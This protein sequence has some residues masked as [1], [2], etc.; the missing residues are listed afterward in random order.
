MEAGWSS[1]RE[2]GAGPWMW[3]L[4]H[5]GLSFLICTMGPGGAPHA[6][7]RPFSGVLVTPLL[8]SQPSPE[9]CADPAG[10]WGSGQLCLPPAVLGGNSHSWQCRA[11]PRLGL[12]PLLTPLPSPYPVG[13]PG[14]DPP[15]F[16]P[17]GQL[18][19][20]PTPTYLLRGVGPPLTI[21]QPLGPR[22]A[23]VAAWSTISPLP[24]WRKSGQLGLLP[25][26]LHHCAGDG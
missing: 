1:S 19:L 2:L 17:W 10:G 7:V 9:F 14:C 21:K 5:W 6:S 22:L 3:F 4:C 25:G 11:R 26:V 15:T 20:L 8:T 18:G 16:Q 23:V 12:W 24:L 13:S